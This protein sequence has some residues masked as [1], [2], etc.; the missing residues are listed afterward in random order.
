MYLLEALEEQ[1]YDEPFEPEELAEI[2]NLW[3]DDHRNCRRDLRMMKKLELEFP[4]SGV[5]YRLIFPGLPAPH[6]EQWSEL[7]DLLAAQ[8]DGRL[9]SNEHSRLVQLYRKYANGVVR[10]YKPPKYDSWSKSL[11]SLSVYYGLQIG[12]P[13]AQLQKQGKGGKS[14]ARLKGVALIRGNIEGIDLE[15]ACESALA[16]ADLDEYEQEHLMNIIEVK[17]VVAAKIISSSVMRV[18]TPIFDPKEDEVPADAED[19]YDELPF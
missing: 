1:L 2:L 13:I 6:D 3:Y 8:S 12:E 7:F 19:V 14:L 18:G 16:E 11:D 15:A 5:A 9:D 17:E 10:R 4:Y